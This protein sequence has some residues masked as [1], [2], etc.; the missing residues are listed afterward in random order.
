MTNE[1]SNTGSLI[2]SELWQAQLEEL[3]H[4]QLLGT[5]FVRQLDFP[6]GTTFTLPSLGAALV[7]DFPEG[8]N[9]IR[10]AIDTGELQF[11]LNDPIASAG[12]LTEVLMEDSMW[13]AELMA[14]VPMEQAVAVME[15]FETDVLALANSQPSGQGNVNAING[16]DHR[17]VAS[18]T[19][20]VMV[21]KDFAFARYALTK[22]KVP[23][24]NLIAIVDPS[25]AFALETSTNL[26]NVSNNPQWEGII[27]TGIEK[28]MRFIRNVYGFDVFESN[29]LATA[30]ETIGSATTTAGIA[31]IFMSADRPNL[32]PFAVA[33]RRHPVLRSSVNDQNHNIEYDTSARYGTGMV[34]ANNLVV[35]PS[36]TDQV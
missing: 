9:L 10:D 3:L 32:L 25:V 21:P 13:R 2:R 23:T 1:V 20:E 36:D 31:N 8:S 4:E 28:N 22:A 33:W 12:A 35:I 24:N 26:V 14:G 5:P 30:N 17:R 27:E 7:R 34:R 6:D 19:N 29:L 18:G 15:R 16:I 11:T